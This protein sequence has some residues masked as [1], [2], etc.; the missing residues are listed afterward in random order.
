LLETA[1][2][3]NKR[4]ELGCV[5]A[6]LCGI[7]GKGRTKGRA[8]GAAFD[9]PAVASIHMALR[10]LRCC[11]LFIALLLLAYHAMPA[12]WLRWETPVLFI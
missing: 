7:A 12:A 3:E 6:T 2:I 5:T 9:P 4:G 8:S 1:L 11:R 10:V